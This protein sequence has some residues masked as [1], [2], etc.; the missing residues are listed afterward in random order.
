MSAIDE[1]GGI[2]ADDADEYLLSYIEFRYGLGELLTTEHPSFLTKED[3]EL[4]QSRAVMDG[5][6]RTEEQPEWDN[7]QAPEGE[8]G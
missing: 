8:E 6:R 4:I 7:P 1:M 5:F 3:G 2:V